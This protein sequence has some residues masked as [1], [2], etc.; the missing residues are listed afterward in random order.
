M[1]IVVLVRILWTAG[2]SRIAIHQ[3]RALAELGHD[4]EI[5]FIRSTSGG[6]LYRELLRGLAYRVLNSDNDSI[7]VPVYDWLTGVFMPSRVGA[8]RLDYNLI[9]GAWRQL[10]G[11]TIDLIVCHDQWGGLAGYLAKRHLGVPYCVYM[12]EK[13]T[14]YPWVKGPIRSQLA[15]LASWYERSILKSA[16]AVFGVT[17]RVA[18]TIEKKH[19]IKTIGLLPGLEWKGSEGNKPEAGS[20]VALSYWSD[21][22]RP[23]GYLD[24]IEKLPNFRLKMLGNWIAPDFKA[25]FEIQLEKRGLKERV[26]IIDS[27]SESAKLSYL[28]KAEFM[29]RFGWGR[30]GSPRAPLRLWKWAFP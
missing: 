2:T 9:R 6:D 10:R 28:R 16:S 18:A 17:D 13:V 29:V 1:K 3:A 23:E 25:A 5:V 15:R 11:Q 4:V 21:V 30:P 14:D 20:L 27:L 8:G 19:G 12:H 7:F 24:F 22:K 26:R